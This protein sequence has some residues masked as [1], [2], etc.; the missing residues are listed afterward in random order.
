[1]LV[2][3]SHLAKYQT[4]F[5]NLGQTM[6]MRLSNIYANSSL[7]TSPVYTAS[8][9][10]FNKN[11]DHGS[12]D[13]YF[14]DDFEATVDYLAEC[15]QVAFIVPFPKLIKMESVLK[16]RGVEKLSVGV[17]T[18]FERRLGFYLSGWIPNFVH[19]R[20]RGL[21]SSGVF[22]W[23]NK[24][25]AVHLV[26]VRVSSMRFQQLNATN[27][28][29]ISGLNLQM[30]TKKQKQQSKHLMHLILALIICNFISFICLLLELFSCP[31]FRIPNCVTQLISM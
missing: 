16:I 14:G 12:C 2:A 11:L 5:D 19:M 6:P 30:S 9:A 20:I 1:M 10:F 29:K 17:K 13:M 21:L 25:V 23:W 7:W 31:F 24:L 3:Y 28:N 22:E 18:L 15:D 27:G 26:Q 4:Y 8:K